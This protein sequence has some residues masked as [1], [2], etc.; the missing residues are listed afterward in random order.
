MTALEVFAKKLQAQ[1]PQSTEQTL[2]AQVLQALK[3]GMQMI[4]YGSPRESIEA[5]MQMAVWAYGLE[6]VSGAIKYLEQYRPLL[7]YI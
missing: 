6:V 7:R 4:A 2:E 3:T 5:F 1:V